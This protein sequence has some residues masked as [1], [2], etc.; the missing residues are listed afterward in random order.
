VFEVNN[1]YYTGL[2]TPSL[3]KGEKVAREGFKFFIDFVN[4]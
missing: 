2:K 1:F 3:P 4:I